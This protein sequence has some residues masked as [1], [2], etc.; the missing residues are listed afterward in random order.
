M[1]RNLGI[2]G[3]MLAVFA[4][5]LLMI[6]GTGSFA[7][8]KI[9][10]VN[11]L[12]SEMRSRWLP[13]TQLLGDLHAYT[14]QYRIA[15]S[16]LLV[17]K[18]DSA[19]YQTKIQLKNQRAAISG[20][21]KDYLPLIQSPDQRVQ[22]NNLM[23]NWN[24]YSD[25][26]D[27][28]QA[29]VDTNDPGDSGLFDGAA[30]ENFYSIEDNILQLIDLN[31]KGGNAN[32]M[33]AQAIYGK[34]RTTMIWAV[35]AALGIS[36]ILSVWM[37]R[38]VAGPIRKMSDMVER[39]VGGDLEVVIPGVKRKDEL[40]SLARAMDSFKLLFAADQQRAREDARR[41]T[42]T[43]ATIDAIGE[44]LSALAHGHLTHEV[45]E[46]IAGPLGQLHCDYNAAVAKL[47]ETMS[48]IVDGADVIRNGA[49]E[50]ADAS[51]DL[52]LRTEKQ[53]Q[54]LAHVSQTL[55]EFNQS[56]QVTADNARQ[57]SEKLAVARQSAEQVDQTAKLAVVAMRSIGASSREMNEIISAIDALAFQTN[58]LALN[59]GVEAA[60]AGDAGRGFAVVA[61]EVRALAQRSSDAASHIRE[62][63]A[64]SGNEINQGVALVESSGK[65]LRQI[66]DEAI[67]V[68][69]L[70]DEIAQASEAQATGLQ[71]IT[72]MVSD[73]DL[74]TQQNAAMVEQATASS[75]NLSIETQRLADQVSFFDLGRSRSASRPKPAP[76][77]AVRLPAVSG[78]LAL[79]A[80]DNEWEEF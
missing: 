2:A 55:V 33:Q 16:E 42:E 25:L 77:K 74:V 9:G 13:A 69:A 34:S 71:Q 47:I 5:F 79:S 46:E 52:S 35:C 4:I 40:G 61:N 80:D 54:T 45:S 14:S 51:S 24:H 60:R 53:A 19:K 37:F 41:A 15:Q 17:A 26:S 32:A 12:S 70:A 67:E 22:F 56:V 7:V 72:K 8:V 38:G 48:Q 62:L 20:V 10:E 65:Q 6:A 1:Q 21:L 44:G 43:Q 23:Q 18:D 75:H 63:V 31:V 58:L 49:S 50:I 78:N 29:M 28:M 39:L 30:L 73:M 11:S 36:L 59:A 64:K 76:L 68:A 27:H 3:K 66:V 57:T